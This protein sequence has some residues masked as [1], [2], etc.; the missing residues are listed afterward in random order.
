MKFITSMLTSAP[1]K[2]PIELEEPPEN[3]FVYIRVDAAPFG[4]P[5]TYVDPDFVD[6]GFRYSASAPKEENIPAHIQV[7]LDLP[8]ALAEAEKEH[9]RHSEEQKRLAALVLDDWVEV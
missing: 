3:T 4:A 7:M 6:P 1:V 2:Q 5:S 9:Q 8:K